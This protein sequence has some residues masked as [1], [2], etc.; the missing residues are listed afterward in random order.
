MCFGKE[1]AVPAAEITLKI[2]VNGDEK[3]TCMTKFIF[4]E[5]VVQ[6]KE[7]VSKA[8]QKRNTKRTSSEKAMLDG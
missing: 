1:W 3:V 8:M 6:G 4:T 2:G 7:T 5:S